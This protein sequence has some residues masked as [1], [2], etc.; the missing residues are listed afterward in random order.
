[1]VGLEIVPDSGHHFCGGQQA[2]VFHNGTLAMDSAGFDRIEPGTFDWQA[3]GQR[4]HP[5]LPFYPLIVLPH[6]APHLAADMPGGVVQTSTSTRLRSYGRR[7]PTHAR[8]AVV[9][10]L[11]GRPSTNRRQALLVSVRRSP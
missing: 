9:T 4:S 5:T 10:W 2:G 7:S 8:K 3:A 1:M 6:P 11:T